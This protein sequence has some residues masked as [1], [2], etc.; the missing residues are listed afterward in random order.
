MR[1]RLM[2][3]TKEM[4]KTLGLYLWEIFEVKS[5]TIETTRHKYARETK[6]VNCYRNN[7]KNVRFLWYE[8]EI[9]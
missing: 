9:I 4:R 7:G 8:V 2:Y 5:I 1:C 3:M 6:W